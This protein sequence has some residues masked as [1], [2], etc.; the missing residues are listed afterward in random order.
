MPDKGSRGAGDGPSTAIKTRDRGQ[1]ELF[2]ALDLGTNSCRMLIAE[3]SGSEFRVV[4]AFSKSVR[5]GMDLER[6]GYLSRPAIR[7]TISAA[8]Q[9]CL[10]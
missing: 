4:D 7:R 10:L 5:L 6:T 9:S 8:G 2:A 3:P 1:R